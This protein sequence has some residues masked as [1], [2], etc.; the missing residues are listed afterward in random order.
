[1]GTIRK[2]LC[3]RMSISGDLEEAEFYKINLSA[4]KGNT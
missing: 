3:A 4:V 2:V 1:M